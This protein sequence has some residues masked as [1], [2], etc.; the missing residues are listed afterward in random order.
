[1]LPLL[2]RKN[3][4]VWFFFSFTFSVTRS[5]Y[6]FACS[7]P[8]LVVEMPP[9]DYYLQILL[10]DKISILNAFNFSSAQLLFFSILQIIIFSKP[11]WVFSHPFEVWILNLV[12]VLP[13]SHIKFVNWI[14]LI[15]VPYCI[16]LKLWQ[17]CIYLPSNMSCFD[18]NVSLKSWSITYEHPLPSPF[19]S[20]IYIT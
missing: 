9:K 17:D 20:H 16:V 18:Q 2:V 7:L 4:T 5:C 19:P 1:M 10:L 15:P 3:T 6:G 13:Y 11:S 12:T 8:I 14:S